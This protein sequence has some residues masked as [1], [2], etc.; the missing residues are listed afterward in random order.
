MAQASSECWALK[1]KLRKLKC[2]P[3]LSES[4]SQQHF[5]FMR[6][7]SSGL[8]YPGNWKPGV[9][10]KCLGWAHGRNSWASTEQEELEYNIRAVRESSVRG[11]LSVTLLKLS[12]TTRAFSAIAADP[13]NHG[14]ARGQSPHLTSGEVMVMFKAMCSLGNI[15]CTLEHCTVERAPWFRPWGWCLP[16]C[17]LR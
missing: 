4:S 16:M 9:K 13:E 5:I 1:G 15:V 11:W 2:A 14:R 8:T 6:A 10:K 3:L 17:I 7:N 12:M